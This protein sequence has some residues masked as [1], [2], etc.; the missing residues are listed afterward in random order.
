LL[1]CI[2]NSSNLHE[3]DAYS[4][5]ADINVM[6]INIQA[7]N[8]SMNE[9]KNVEGRSGNEYARIIYS[10]RDEFRSRRP[11]D[12]ISANR[13]ILI[14]DE[15]QKMGSAESAT[16]RALKKNFKPL[17]SINYSATHKTRHNLLY[18]L[19][20]LDAFNKRLVKKIE[21]KGL[22]I[23]NLSGTSRY[24]YLQDILLEKNQA[25]RVKMEIEVKR[26]GGIKREVREFREGDSLYVTSEN[27]EEYRGLSLTKI[28]PWLSQ[29]EFS[30]G[31]ILL[32]SVKLLS[33][34]V[35]RFV[36]T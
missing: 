28:D 10:E 4:Q 2:Y 25:P 24:V 31:E 13:P 22:E 36:S 19:D 33:P 3:L 16:Q 20:P 23:Q 26:A 29:V 30:N 34:L 15:P 18:V 7:F 32:G 12:V 11:I 35:G 1:H 9:E 21:V 27:L 6:I 14:L 8:T 17:F 5:S